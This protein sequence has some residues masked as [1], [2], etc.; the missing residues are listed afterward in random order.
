MREYLDHQ[1]ILL[2]AKAL[3]KSSY[4]PPVFTYQKRQWLMARHRLG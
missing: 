3:S 4:T 2:A 1:L